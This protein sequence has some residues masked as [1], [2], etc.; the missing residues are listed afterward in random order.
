MF[1][2][3]TRNNLQG[4]SIFSYVPSIISWINHLYLMETLQ[5]AQIQPLSSLDQ[6][7]LVDYVFNRG[8][9]TSFT[10]EA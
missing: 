6:N 9:L 3:Y 8:N 7:W 1:R 2:I 4:I 5:R 10:D